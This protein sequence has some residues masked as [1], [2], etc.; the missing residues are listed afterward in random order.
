M[1]FLIYPSL[2]QPVPLSFDPTNNPSEHYQPWSYPLQTICRN[3]IAWAFIAAMSAGPFTPPMGYEQPTVD[4]YLTAL[5]EPIRLNYK[6]SI[7]TAAQQ[8]TAFQLDNAQ[9]PE[10]VTESRWHQPW[11][12]PYNKATLTIRFGS[13]LQ[14]SFIGDTANTLLPITN[15]VWFAPL[16]EP[17]R[18]K[19]GL[20]AWLQQF[21][22]K[23]FPEIPLANQLIQWF[24]NLSEPVRQKIGF[25]AWLQHYWEGPPRLLPTPN[26]TAV[27][28]AFESNT[29]TALFGV[30]VYTSTT[31]AASGAGANVSIVEV[32]A[33]RGGAAS[34]RES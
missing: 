8:F 6:Q 27:V 15:P 28:N 33:I 24:S 21:D 31:P 3:R 10:E 32:Q 18:L 5:S 16:S 2:Q 1:T 12:E 26:V 22:P 29:D 17:V 13:Y 7:L 19:I 9:Q 11:S 4:R 20:G 30:Y 25:R 34:I 14:Q 23:Q